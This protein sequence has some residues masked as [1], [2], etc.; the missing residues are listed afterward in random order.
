MPFYLQYLTKW[1]D[2]FLLQ[3][4]PNGTM[5]GYAVTV[6]PEFRRLGLAKN[7]M[8]YLENSSWGFMLRYDGYFVDLFVRVSNTPAIGMYEKIGYSVYRRV[9]GY[10]SGDDDGEDAFGNALPRDKDKKSII[11][12]PYPV[13]PDSLMD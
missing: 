2:Y 9:I 3:E 12:L 5:M 7:L 10:Y 13:M 11:P 6:A 1:P 4:D 8:D